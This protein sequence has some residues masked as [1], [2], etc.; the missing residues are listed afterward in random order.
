MSRVAK[1]VVT[2]IGWWLIVATWRPWHLTGGLRHHSP[3]AIGLAAGLVGVGGLLGVWLFFPHQGGRVLR[4]ALHLRA[5]LGWLRWPLAVA[6]AAVFPL[7]ALYVHP[8]VVKLAPSSARWLA[9]GVFVF[10]AA[11]LLAP[12]SADTLR[13]PDLL[14]GGLLVAATFAFLAAYTNVTAYPFTLTWSE[15]NRLWDYSLFFGRGRYLYPPGRP[16]FSYT[17]P[18][19]RLLWG[20]IFLVPG[21]NIFWVRFWNAVLFSV[22]YVLLGWMAFRRP[23]ALSATGLWA[24]LWGYLFIA[25]GPIYAPL[26]LSAL[27]VLIAETASSLGVGVPL[28]LAAGYYAALTRFT[29]LF[30]P[31][32]WAVLLAA[33]RLKPSENV[34][35]AVRRALWLGGSGLAGA[36][37]SGKALFTFVDT[38]TA[39]AGKILGHAAPAAPA[40]NVASS[41]PLLWGRLAPNPTFPPGI[42]LGLL[43]AVGPVVTLWWLW[44]RRG[45][46]RLPRRAAWGVFGILGFFLAVGVVAS[47]KI[48]GGSN[49][50]NLDM[51]LLGVLF[52]TAVLWQRGGGA[53][54][55]QSL[56][57][58][59]EQAVL[60]ALVLFPMYFVFLYSRPVPTLPPRAHW[61]QALSRTAQAVQD[62]VVQGGEVLFIDQRQLL[63]FVLGREVPL[64]PEYEKK[65]MMDQAMAANKAYFARY[66]HDLA[67]HRF[68]LIVT[69]PLHVRYKLA[70][71]GSFAA[72]NNAWVRWV[73]VPTLCYYRPLAV[74][75]E[76]GLELLVP[77]EEKLRCEQALPVPPSDE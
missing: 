31:A 56:W 46:W 71:A 54:I 68:A 58:R 27:L 61:Q 44:Y 26:V 40:A 74:F 23:R 1:G 50:H 16:I 59:G 42:V 22:P 24:G 65:Y 28:M 11:L 66:Y 13:L 29:W 36:L 55:G 51:F 25:Q 37:L 15:G 14:R 47:L 18:G 70:E 4:G 12:L 8:L 48:G 43:L 57:K 19:R 6:W 30:A 45:L 41:Q 72:E 39:M 62:A 9:Y 52:V 60:V 38:A 64:I 63:T 67:T 5:R 20:L 17:D 21:V 7:A 2:L 53:H 33:A 77:R 49:L 73:S 32:L 3:A 35:P 76:E 34:R 69:E 75:P 10:G